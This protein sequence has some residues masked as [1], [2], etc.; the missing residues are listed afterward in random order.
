MQDGKLFENVKKCQTNLLKLKRVSEFPPRLFDCMF[1]CLLLEF[2]TKGGGKV[3]V[4]RH[5][6]S[7]FNVSNLV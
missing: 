4:G 2:L 5:E 6:H 7:F 1:G 3:H